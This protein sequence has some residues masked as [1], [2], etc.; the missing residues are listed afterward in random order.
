MER[1]SNCNTGN[2]FRTESEASDGWEAWDAVPRDGPAVFVVDTKAFDHGVI[3]GLWLEVSADGTALHDQLTELLGREPEE[4][5]WAIIDQ[6]GL[7]AL[8][9]PETMPT[10][11]LSTVVADLAAE[12]GP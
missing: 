9:A 5:T 2:G 12:C 6:V 11:G 10:S 1:T 8:M 3:R 7:G 4:G